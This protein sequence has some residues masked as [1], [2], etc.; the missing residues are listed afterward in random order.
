MLQFQ[1]AFPSVNGG[2]AERSVMK[3]KA[4]PPFDPKAFLAKAELGRTISK[5][6]VD[7]IVFS[8]GRSGRRCFLHPEW[9]GQNHR[10]LRAR[11]GSSRRSPGA[12]RI[13][14]RRM[15][16]RPAAAHGD[17]TAM[18]ECE[19]MRLEKAAIVR[20][21]HEE[22]AFSEIFVSHI[23]ARTIR[24]EEDLSTNCSILARSAWH[25]LFSCWLISARKAGPSRLMRKSAKRCSRK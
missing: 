23:L 4:E 24:V 3:S 12:G 11:K 19:I 14:R 2:Q 5:Y 1:P 13:L 21:L 9:E 22:P 15:P 25:G 18:T 7:Q 6:R 17:S 16:S 10:H 8:Q 20:V